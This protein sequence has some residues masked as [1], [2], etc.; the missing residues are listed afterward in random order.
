MR[1]DSA[2]GTPTGRNIPT[3]SIYLCCV[4]DPIFSRGNFELPKT[5]RQ[6]RI[7]KCSASLFSS[8]ILLRGFHGHQRQKA[9]A[10]IQI[11]P[12]IIAR[13]LENYTLFNEKEM[14]CSISLVILL[15]VFLFFLQF[16]EL[17]FR[18]ILQQILWL[19]TARIIGTVFDSSSNIIE[20][21]SFD[22]SALQ[23]SR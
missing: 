9:R 19:P 12:E 22:Y 21:N 7:S 11:N 5:K 20:R 18:D 13:S 6:R 10:K 17:L 23:T 14:P 4:L 8:S 15:C 3:R 1:A 2:L 16:H